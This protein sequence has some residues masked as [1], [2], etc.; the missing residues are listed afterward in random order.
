MQ[1]L[2]THDW[3]AAILFWVS[4]GLWFAIEF[5]VRARSDSEGRTSREWT[6]SLIVFTQLA[7]LAVATVVA[8]KNPAPIPGAP[9]WPV[10]VGLSLLWI[11]V[12]FRLWAIITLGRFF[13]MV[14]VIQ[15]GHRVVDSGPYR[16]L[17]HP[18]YTGGL[19]IVTG[20]G[21]AEGDWISLAIMIVF[22]LIAYLIRIR[23]EERALLEVLG[24][25]Y[26]AYAKRTSRLV[27]GLF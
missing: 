5:V 12:A 6:L 2:I 11:G 7:S 26:A 1:S 25:E 15:D 21:L 27:P 18:S 13:K 16:W 3:T 20:L 23:V 14:V 19:I 17:R 10:A 4:F 9:W 24:E 8:Y 22:P